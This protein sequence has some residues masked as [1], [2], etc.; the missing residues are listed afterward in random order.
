MLVDPG[1]PALL[2]IHSI[3]TE[4]VQQMAH[5]HVAYYDNVKRPVNGYQMKPVRQ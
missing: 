3:K 2:T 4:F 5:N 1:K